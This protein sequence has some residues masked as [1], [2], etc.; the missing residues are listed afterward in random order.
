MTGLVILAFGSG[1]LIGML[2]MA[3]LFV[4]ERYAR[5]AA[6]Q[7]IRASAEQQLAA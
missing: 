7:R 6:E 3:G 2:M 5:K 4:K 1:W